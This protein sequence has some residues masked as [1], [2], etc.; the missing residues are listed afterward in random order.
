MPSVYFNFSRHSV[1]HSH[2]ENVNRTT[3]YHEMTQPFADPNKKTYQEKTYGKHVKST[4]NAMISSIAFG[5]IITTGLHVWKGMLTGLAIQV[6]MAPFNLFENALAKYFLMGG[7]IENAQADKIFDEKTREE[8]TPSDEIVDEMNNPVET[9][10]AP[11]KETRSFED[12]LLDTWQAGEKADIAPLM[13][14]LTD[15]N[16]NHVTKEDGWTPIMMMSGLGSKKTVS[17]MKMMKALGAD[18][19]VVD[20]EGW[21]A[22]HWA[23]FHG[24][25]EA[26]KLLLSESGFDGVKLGLHTAE[27]KDNLCP[28][29]HAKKEKNDEVAKIIEDATTTITPPQSDITNEEG[30]RKRK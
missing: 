19:S 30:L 2:T 10:P 28:L 26:A 25:K 21:N 23:A 3:Y 7:S 18:P 6:V 12:I 15:K 1:S 5:I 4:A 14:A 8:L 9:A 24:S 11:A 16:V 20:G 13:A 29:D 27:D 17:A 22:L